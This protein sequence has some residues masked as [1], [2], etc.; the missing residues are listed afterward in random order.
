[1]SLYVDELNEKLQA[2]FQK[3]SGALQRILSLCDKDTFSEFGGFSKQRNSDFLEGTPNSDGDGV[4]CGSCYIGGRLVFVYSQ[5]NAV[6]GGSIGQ[7]HGEKIVKTIEMAMQ[8]GAPVLG[9]ID[10]KGV[11]LSEN[12]DALNAYGSIF[13]AM[14]RASGVVPIISI[15]AGPCIGGMSFVSAL[16]DFVFM[17]EKDAVL[18][19]QSPSQIAGSE[20]RTVSFEGL[21]GAV[22]HSKNSGLVHYAGKDFADIELNVKK[23]IDFLPSNN[24]EDSV[25]L[26]TNDPVERVCAELDD[27]CNANNID[28]TEIIK[29]IS[30][31]GN[32]FELLKDFEDSICVGFARFNGFTT[33]IVANKGEK[34]LL[35]NKSMSKAVS[36]VNFCDSFNIPIVTLTNVAGFVPSVSEEHNGIIMRAAE[37]MHSFCAATVPK[38]NVLVGNAYGS[39]YVI[40]NSKH[41]GADMCY[42]WPNAKISVMDADAAVNIMLSEEIK[43]AKNS[44]K[45]RDELIEKYNKMQASPYV[46]ASR[47]YVDSVIL[48]SQTRKVIADALEMLATK[49]VLAPSRKHQSFR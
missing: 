35:N 48:P 40:M 36:F 34:P 8:M 23:L 29:S 31:S 45:K 19:C 4:V 22:S 38:I 9:I 15:V 41:I 17:T 13:N 27:M 28:T 10:S 3:K 21:G 14:S 12:F 25:V 46:A 33:G 32:F 26:L 37:L 49:R 16:S 7:V 2:N 5:N 18:F 30:D 1:M 6:L 43:N 11:R 47:G 24:M 20:S 42:S 39:A 44:L